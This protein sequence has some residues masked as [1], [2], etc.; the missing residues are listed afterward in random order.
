MAVV[1]GSYSGVVDR[2]E[3]VTVARAACWSFA[4]VLMVCWSARAIGGEALGARRWFFWAVFILVYLYSTV[5]I[6]IFWI[7]AN[8]IVSTHKAQT[9]MPE[10][11]H[12]A[13]D[14]SSRGIGPITRTSESDS[15]PACRHTVGR[16]TTPAEAQALTDHGSTPPPLA[17]GWRM[18]APLTR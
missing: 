10:T 6:G 13:A 2:F 15:R 8:D 17:D 9:T 5:M 12:S 18:S 4:A 7:C 3:R 16:V 14:R 1:V 11:R